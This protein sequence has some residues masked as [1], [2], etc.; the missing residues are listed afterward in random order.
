MEGRPLEGRSIEGRSVEGRSV[1][2]RPPE[3][4]PAAVVGRIAEHR[5]R[6]H[7]QSLRVGLETALRRA[8]STEEET[9]EPETNP[10]AALLSTRQ[11]LSQALLVSEVLGKPRALRPYRLS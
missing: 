2:G 4:R 9:A 3:D 11:G 10:V 5:N 7:E 8:D 1:E 6:F